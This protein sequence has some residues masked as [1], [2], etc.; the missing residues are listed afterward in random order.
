[1]KMR[2]PLGFLYINVIPHEQPIAM[3]VLPVMR[4][5]EAAPRKV[6]IMDFSVDTWSNH[7]MPAL[8]ESGLRVLVMSKSVSKAWSIPLHSLAVVR[9]I[10]AAFPAIT[11][12]PDRSSDEDNGEA[13]YMAMARRFFTELAPCGLAT[14][15]VVLFSVIRMHSTWLISDHEQYVNYIRWML[16]GNETGKLLM[17]SNAGRKRI[18]DTIDDLLR[19]DILFRD[20]TNWR[21]FMIRSLRDIVRNDWSVCIRNDRTMVIGGRSV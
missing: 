2:M 6:G 18:L 15:G 13:F 10:K 3:Q 16:N 12:W 17:Q 7:I 19:D 9:V 21:V 14:T 5:A 20:N 4:T 8:S 11:N 1:M